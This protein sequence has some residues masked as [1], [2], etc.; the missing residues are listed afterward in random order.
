MKYLFILFCLSLC[1]GVDIDHAD[2]DISRIV[3][4]SLINEDFGDDLPPSVGDSVPR[5]NLPALLSTLTDLSVNPEQMLS[6]ITLLSHMVYESSTTLIEVEA[7]VVTET[8]NRATAEASAL[9][10]LSTAATEADVIRTNGDT[11]AA[12]IRALAQTLLDEANTRN[13]T[14]FPIL[15]DERDTINSVIDILGG[16][17]LECLEGYP[18]N[19]CGHVWDNQILGVN[20]DAPINSALEC[21]LVQRARIEDS[22]LVEG[23]FW[24]PSVGANHGGDCRTYNM[25]AF[26][27]CNI[28]WAQENWA[29][30][31]WRTC[32]V[33][34]VDAAAGVDGSQ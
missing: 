25:A 7:N 13:T 27:N 22:S 29:A 20:A 19:N 18:H 28:P 1:L 23:I 2:S 6:V 9:Q 31:A 21:L 17:N 26:Y 32:A 12:N 8:S 4:S 3:N 15:S 34:I 10:V 11:N 16:N 14:F 24:H 33:R 5:F 30:N